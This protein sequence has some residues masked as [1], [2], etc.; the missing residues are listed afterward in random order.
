GNQHHSNGCKQLFSDCF[1]IHLG[2]SSFF[3]PVAL[4]WHRAEILFSPRL[5]RGYNTHPELPLGR[6]WQKSLIS[7]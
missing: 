2:K 6:S 4:P 5:W 3:V 1:R 7:D